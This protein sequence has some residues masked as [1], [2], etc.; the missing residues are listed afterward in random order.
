MNISH[1]FIMRPVMTTLV[2]V[3]ILIFGAI[4]Y[5][6]LPVSELPDIEFPTISVTA[7]LPGADAET[8]ASAV[9]TPLEN[10]FSTIAG[11]DTMTAVSTLGQTSIN[12]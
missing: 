1:P 9:A 12:M 4:G 3:A 8:M 7:V 10:Q 2:M 6:K 11:I 5:V